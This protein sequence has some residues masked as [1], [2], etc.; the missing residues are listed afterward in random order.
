VQA[1]L[2]IHMTAEDAVRAARDLGT[3]QMFPL[4]W[5]TFNLQYHD[6]NEPIKRATAEAARIGVQLITPRV[7]EMVGS[8]FRSITWW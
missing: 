4:H 2:D 7:G 5:A 3:E 6:W 8:D 1:W